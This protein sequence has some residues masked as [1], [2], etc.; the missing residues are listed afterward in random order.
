MTTTEEHLPATACPSWCTLKPG[1]P[2]DSEACGLESDVANLCR[3]H[4]GPSFGKF[5]H[6]GGIEFANSAGVVEY[7]IHL[8]EDISADTV[9]DRA[10]L[11]ELSRQA[12]A[13]AAWLQAHPAK[14]WLA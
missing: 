13:A 8:S 1:H 10:E 6:I 7:D 3:G 2:W 14:V 12:L 5:I 9:M 4:A 11:I